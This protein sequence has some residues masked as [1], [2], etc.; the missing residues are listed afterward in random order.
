MKISATLASL[1][2]VGITNA[3]IPYNQMPSTNQIGVA[4]SLEVGTRSGI[5]SLERARLPHQA[6][7]KR[8]DSTGSGAEQL[9]P[10]ALT[11]AK[12]VVKPPTAIISPTV[13]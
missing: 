12:A 8:P 4:P 2:L 10:S 1:L 5:M 6:T 3:Q 9:T 13:E 11:A 7:L